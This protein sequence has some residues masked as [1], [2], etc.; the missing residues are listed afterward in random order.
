MDF[1][2]YANVE[3]LLGGI[4]VGTIEW[5]LRNIGNGW[6]ATATMV[7]ANTS[8]TVP[9][10]TSGLVVIPLYGN[11]VIVPLDQTFYMLRFYSSAGSFIAEVPYFC[12]GEGLYDLSTYAPTFPGATHDVV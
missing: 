4:E 1:Q 11:D 7:I 8:G 2:F 3:N 12:F 10:P 9:V 5:E 6:P